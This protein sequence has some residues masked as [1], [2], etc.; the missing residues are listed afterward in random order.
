MYNFSQPHLFFENHIQRNDFI[1]FPW[2]RF[3][4]F[5]MGLPFIFCCGPFFSV[6]FTG[7]LSWPHSA[8]LSVFLN[9][10]INLGWASWIWTFLG[11]KVFD[12]FIFNFTFSFSFLKMWLLKLESIHVACICV[13]HY[14]SSDELCPVLIHPSLYSN[15]FRPSRPHSSLSAFLRPFGHSLPSLISPGGFVIEE[16]HRTDICKLKWS[17]KSI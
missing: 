7:F 16:S 12:L 9:I 11:V 4:I 5:P 17:W 8:L 14:I 2:K 1:F 10:T 13:S 6:G 15:S 3:Y